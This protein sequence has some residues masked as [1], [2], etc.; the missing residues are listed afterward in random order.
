MPEWNLPAVISGWCL[1][2]I[3]D[4]T[5]TIID[6]ATGNAPLLTDLGTIAF[7]VVWLLIFV[8]IAG[9]FMLFGLSFVRSKY[10][11]FRQWF[12]IRG[13]PTMTV[14]SLPV[15]E[16]NLEGEL[17]STAE[18]PPTTPFFGT[19]CAYACWVVEKRDAEHW[20]T[21]AAG[22]PQGRMRL[23]DETGDVLVERFSDPDTSVVDAPEISVERY[24][25]EGDGVEDRTEYA[26][27]YDGEG[28]RAS[29]RIAAANVET[30]TVDAGEAPP[31]EIAEWCERQG[32]D[33][34]GSSRR[35]YRELVIPP[36]TTAYIHGQAR[37]H[38]AGKRAATTSDLVVGAADDD[39][40]LLLA[41]RP[42]DELVDLLA[43]E[44]RLRFFVGGIM[45]LI[46]FAGVAIGLWFASQW[47]VE[48]SADLLSIRGWTLGS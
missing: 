48:I 35:R 8:G 18:A 17:H 36:G 26:V 2:R 22:D 28:Y 19:S 3:G 41:D 27:T 15:G 7:A 6:V 39:P 21:V 1:Q 10:G 46:G 45:F 13:T 30:V 4:V 29:V 40:G 14:Q 9:Y 34:R 23:A 16:V 12:Q 24:H 38:E 32:L 43:W 33:A 47:I 5:P 44:W 31:E 37:R 11:V 42:E 20:E 25:R